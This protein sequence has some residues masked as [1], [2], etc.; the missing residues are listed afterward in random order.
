MSEPTPVPMCRKCRI[1]RRHGEKSM[2]IRCI[3]IRAASQAK[4]HAWY[5]AEGRRMRCGDERGTKA[6]STIHC[7]PCQDMHNATA[8]LNRF[9]QRKE[10]KG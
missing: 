7:N 5:A 4:T 8:R 1:R 6:R 10:K 9:H 2:C 3:H